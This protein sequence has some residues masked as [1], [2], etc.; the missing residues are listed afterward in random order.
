MT[1]TPDT[2]AQAVISEA[3]H[4]LTEGFKKIQHCVDQLT[5]EQV[6]W[7]PH[8]SMNSIANVLL[9]LCG[10][11]EQWLI[12]GIGELPDNRDRP[13]EFADRSET[14]KEE[15]LRQLEETLQRVDETL[16]SVSAESLLAPRRIQGFDLTVLGAIFDA[17]PHF[18]GH[19]QETIYVTRTL[20]GEQY[21]FAWAPTTPEQGA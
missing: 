11:L 20:L 15:L 18:S 4:R 1:T 6:W 19:V 3:R 12:N 7:R 16:A 5:Q 10:N 17:V 21:R 2:L 9:H 14:S 8:E 13:A